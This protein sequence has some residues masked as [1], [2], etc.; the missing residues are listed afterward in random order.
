MLDLVLTRGLV[1]RAVS[2][3]GWLNSDHCEVVASIVV[4]N[5]K[6][7]LVTRTTVFNYK[8]A[9][10]SGLR[11]SLSLAPWCMLDGLDVNRAV[12]VFYALLE[13]A[14]HDHVPRVTLRRLLP[15]WFDSAVRGA[16]RS[17]EAAFRRLRR[18]PTDDARHEFSEK[19]AAF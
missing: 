19:R 12:D 8:R 17:K 4:P 5:L 13:A 6:P 9:D 15:P 10:F 18:N 11:R 3:E 14:I 1:C 2:R 7:L 16:L